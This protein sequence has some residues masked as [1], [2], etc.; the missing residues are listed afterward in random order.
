MPTFKIFCTQNKVH[1]HF[2]ILQAFETVDK[3]LRE[4]NISL[5]F[6][7]SVVSDSFVIPMDCSPPGSFVHGMSQTR[8]MEWV[9][10]SFFRGSSQ[11][12][13]WTYISCLAGG[14]Y[15]HWGTRV[16]ISL[17]L[18]NKKTSVWFKCQ[19]LTLWK[20]SGMIQ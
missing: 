13:G 18:P 7:P 20:I 6:S 1:F 15:Y 2:F 10:I 11:L 12:R 3:R 8:I 5:F 19:K 17:N 14:F 16:N 9:A 4:W